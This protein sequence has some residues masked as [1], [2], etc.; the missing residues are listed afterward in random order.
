MKRT[1]K[2]IVHKA[3]SL[4]RK[5][6]GSQIVENFGDKEQRDFE[7]YIGIIYDYPYSDRRIIT[8]IV[9]DFNAWCMNYT[10]K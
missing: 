4:K 8:Q 6:T 5:L 3:Q 1:V 2:Q 9:F 7:A 10:G